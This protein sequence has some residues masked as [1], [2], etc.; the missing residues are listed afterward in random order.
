[1]NEDRGDVQ[2]CW[3]Q[4]KCLLTNKWIKKIVIHAHRDLSL[5]RVGIA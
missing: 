3:K 1:M 2:R 4:P 5:E